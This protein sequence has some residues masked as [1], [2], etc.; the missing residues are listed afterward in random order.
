[1]DWRAVDK[2][3]VD[4]L[5]KLLAKRGLVSLED[6]QVGKG[7]LWDQSQL[8]HLGCI[9]HR[10]DPWGDTCRGLELLNKKFKT[11]TLSNTY[12][13]LMKGLVAHQNIPFQHVYTSETFQSYKPNPKVYLGAAE[14]IGARPEECALV[15]AHLHDLKSAK[16]C[17]FYA[18]SVVRPFEEKNLELREEN[19]PHLVVEEYENGFITLAER[20]GILS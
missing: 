2:D 14:K 15:A 19:V 11:V 5:P 10:L 13:E 12:T 18:I 7:S 17:G 8:E 4:L 20:L 16:A 6:G 3:R 1:M 9:W